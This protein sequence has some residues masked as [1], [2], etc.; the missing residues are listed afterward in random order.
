MKG[1]FPDAVKLDDN[2]IEIPCHKCGE[3]LLIPTGEGVSGN[4]VVI[5]VDNDGNCWGYCST[6]SAGL[7]L[8]PQTA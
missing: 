4:D 6:C 5:E 1:S 3:K 7:P 2:W 8:G